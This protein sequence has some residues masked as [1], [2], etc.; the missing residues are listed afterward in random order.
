MLL[1]IG[2]RW[3]FWVYRL[4]RDGV[5]C[6]IAGALNKGHEVRCSRDVLDGSRLGLRHVVVEAECCRYVSGN[7]LADA[8]V[9]LVFEFVEL[10]LFSLWR[11]GDIGD[12]VVDHRHSAGDVAIN[13]D[14]VFDLV[15]VV[16]KMRL[17]VESVCVINDSG[18]FNIL[19]DLIFC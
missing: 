13:A 14:S 17:R 6:C 11:R 9:R 10:R 1:G 12:V 19:R 8:N 3:S 18:E 7:W 4:P 16:F 2:A 15:V 5:S